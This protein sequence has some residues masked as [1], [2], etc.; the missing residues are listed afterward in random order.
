MTTKKTTQEYTIIPFN[1]LGIDNFPLDK[2]AFCRDFSNRLTELKGQGL[3]FITTIIK[4]IG[5]EKVEFLVFKHL[6][7]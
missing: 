1:E 4:P 5:H 2:K 6:N 7:P 3:E